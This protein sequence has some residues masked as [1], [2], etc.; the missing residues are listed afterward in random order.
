MAA[1][2]D[3]IPKAFHLKEGEARRDDIP[4]IPRKVIREAVVNALMHRNYR[5]SGPVLIIRYANRLEIRNPGFSLKAV[6]H[7]GEPGSETRNAIVAAVLHETQYA[8]TKGTGIRVMRQMMGAV[9][10]LPPVFESDRG[11]DSFTARY[12]FHHFLGPE[13]VAWLAR[14]RDLHLTSEE[15]KALVFL[16]E[17][18]AINNVTFRDLNQVDT[19]S[20]SRSLRRLRDAGILEQKEKGSATYYR[21]TARFWGDAAEQLPSE[22]SPVPSKVDVV[23][24]MSP[25][26]PSMDEAVPSVPATDLSI[27]A[28]LRAELNGLGRRSDTAVVRRLILDLCAVRPFPA[29]ELA[30]L[31][32]RHAKYLSQQHLQPLLREGHLAYTFPDEPKHPK[33]AYRTVPEKA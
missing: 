7:L 29:S 15:A 26:I 22:P 3:D 11:T 2:L 24:S 17:Q 21:P 16:R 33:Q 25:V 1:I 10:L 12:L 13:D 8:E 6:E 28:S 5:V 19:L 14:F 4:R 30:E 18:G 9:G 27:P 20:A 32:N 23:P 31:L